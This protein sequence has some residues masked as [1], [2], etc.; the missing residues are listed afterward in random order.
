MFEYELLICR[1][2]RQRFP[3]EHYRAGFMKLTKGGRI[4][5][6]HQILGHGRPRFNRRFAIDGGK[7]CKAPMQLSDSRLSEDQIDGGKCI[8]GRKAEELGFGK[9]R[10]R[11]SD[12]IWWGKING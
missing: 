6:D 4:N 7:R 12:L 11:P 5:L 10:W 1:D 9:D 3:E 8:G 2:Q